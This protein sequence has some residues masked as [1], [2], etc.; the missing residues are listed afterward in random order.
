MHTKL[1]LRLGIPTLILA[2]SIILLG[3]KRAEK[4]P[5]K[6]SK[7]RNSTCCKK[8]P[9]PCNTNSQKQDVILENLSRQ[10]IFI[11]AY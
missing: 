6:P 9:A 2:A 10:F 8:S 7:A 4:A 1:I 3:H 11:N 5:G